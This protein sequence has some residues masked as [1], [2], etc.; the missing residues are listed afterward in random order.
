[1]RRAIL[2]SQ[3]LLAVFLTGMLLLFSPIVS[4]FDRPLFWLGIPMIYLYL[5]SV[6]AILI[7]AMALIISSSQK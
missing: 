3:R 4:L 2:T 1:M 6:W 7:A 5:F